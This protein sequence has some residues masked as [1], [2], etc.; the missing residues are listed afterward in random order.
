MIRRENLWCCY[1]FLR[2]AAL[3]SIEPADVNV[4]GGFADACVHTVALLYGKYSGTTAP[5]SSWE[6]P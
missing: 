6:G 4:D 2:L 1:E 3:S 5:L